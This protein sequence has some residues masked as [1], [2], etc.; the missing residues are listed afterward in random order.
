MQERTEMLGQ[1]V[2]CSSNPST[3]VTTHNPQMQVFRGVTARAH[4]VQSLK[5]NVPH[6][7]Y[8]AERGPLLRRGRHSENRYGREKMPKLIAFTLWR[9]E[10]RM[11][12]SR[13]QNVCT[14]IVATFRDSRHKILCI[15]DT[16]GL[17]WR[18]SKRL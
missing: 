4:S 8:S 7:S 5:Y 3:D 11:Q 14:C 15:S 13:I 6:A 17:G 18:E 1:H 12:V 9:Y 2:D 10:C 16:L